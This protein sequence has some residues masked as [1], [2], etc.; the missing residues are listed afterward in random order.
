[1][2]K[3]M[4]ITNRADVA[5][6]AENAGVD[7]IFVDFEYIGKDERQHGMNTVKNHH[8]PADV[9]AIRNV[10]SRSELLVRV[11]PIHDASDL[12]SSS[13]EEIDA[14]I[15]NGADI[16]MLPFFKSA[17]EVRRCIRSIDGRAK[18][19]P[20]LETP[21]A[22]DAVDEILALD[23]IDE[24]HIGINDLSLGYH[25]KFM[26]ELLIDGTVE[27]LCNKFS[28][29]GIPYGFGGI[30]SLGHGLVPAEYII[31]RHYQL[32]SSLAIL[33]RSFCNIQDYTDLNEIRIVFQN[34]IKDIRRFEKECQMH[35]DRK[36]ELYFSNNLDNLQKAI[37]HV[38]QQGAVNK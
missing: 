20:L 13:E 18:F 12:F 32:G 23:G 33:S 7:R 35:V 21:E 16:I 27:K 1:M 36:D 30:A 22:V 5:I 4:Y 6:A 28:E 24:I 15:E 26:F 29:K 19:I 17:E 31:A 25:R 3:L 37:A 8:V 38:L 14:A 9:R 11:N 10:I 34:G 2:L